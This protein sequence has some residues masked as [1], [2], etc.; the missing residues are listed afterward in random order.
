[1]KK[2]ERDK[3]I[4]LRRNGKSFRQIAKEIGVAKSSLSLWLRDVILDP[5]LKKKLSEQPF[6]RDA[7]EK[8][9]KS[10]LSN[11][12][13]KRISVIK[14]AEKEIET[15]TPATLRIAGICL[16]WAEGGKTRS[17]GARFSNSDPYMIR[18]MMRFF[19]TICRVK[20]DRFRCH[21]HT[22]SHLNVSKSEEYWSRITR[23]PLTQ[24]FKTYSKPSK[25]SLGKRDT[26][27]YGTID[28]S[29]HDTKLFLQLMGWIRKIGSVPSLGEN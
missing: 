2:I 6:T 14:Q 20:E 9:R 7:I 19:R 29:I 23:I 4:I 11:E 10:R 17:G 22:Y 18:L 15:L 21:I 1:M 13:Q 28:V 27:P 8:R 25:A 3:A 26:L 12:K 24:F 5:K 16:Y